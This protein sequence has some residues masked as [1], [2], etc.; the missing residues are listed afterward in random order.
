[1]SNFNHRHQSTVNVTTINTNEFRSWARVLRRLCIGIVNLIQIN[2]WL[3]SPITPCLAHS[4]LVTQA[5][6]RPT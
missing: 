4:L 2:M 5:N 6:L 3:G 1:M